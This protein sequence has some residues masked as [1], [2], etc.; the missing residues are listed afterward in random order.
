VTDLVVELGEARTGTLRGQLAR[1]LGDPSLE[2][3]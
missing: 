1:A 3:G 2:I